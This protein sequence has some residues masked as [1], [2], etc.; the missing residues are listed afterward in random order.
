MHKEQKRPSRGFLESESYQ[1]G[2]EIHLTQ[3]LT[4][5]DFLGGYG[6]QKEGVILSAPP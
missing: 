2:A 4:S 6:D 3:S 5:N 1:C